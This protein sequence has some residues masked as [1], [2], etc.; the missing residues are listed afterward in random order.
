M[1]SVTPAARRPRAYVRVQG[2]DALDYL[3]R[4]LSNDLPAEGSYRVF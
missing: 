4:L 2:P 1:Q 3:D